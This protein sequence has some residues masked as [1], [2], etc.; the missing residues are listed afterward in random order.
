MELEHE[1]LHPFGKMAAE[2]LPLHRSGKTWSFGRNEVRLLI[3]GQPLQ[4][5]FSLSPCRRLTADASPAEST[6]VKFH[7]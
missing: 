3:D 5:R 4:L 1:S 6:G 2:C 7:F